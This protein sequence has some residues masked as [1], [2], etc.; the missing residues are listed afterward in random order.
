MSKIYITFKTPDIVED[1]I[2]NADLS[3]QE[4]EKAKEICG[5]FVRWGELLTVV[6]DLEAGTVEMEENT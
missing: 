1:S 4:K 3:E 6:V 2:E 5:R